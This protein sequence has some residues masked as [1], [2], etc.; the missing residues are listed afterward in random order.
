M[1]ENPQTSKVALPTGEGMHKAK[2]AAF[3]C[4]IQ[5]YSH[6]FTPSTVL[7]RYCIVSTVATEQQKPLL[8]WKKKKRQG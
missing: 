4:G 7:L 5:L 2:P 8:L 6:S 3:G 1:A